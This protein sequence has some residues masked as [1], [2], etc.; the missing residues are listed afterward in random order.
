MSGQPKKILTFGTFDLFHMGHFYYLQA[1]RQF[2]DHITA[3]VARDA[4]VQRH[5]EHL[6]WEKEQIRLAK[7]QRSGLVDE[8]RLGYADW[9]RH[10]E[11]LSDVKPD[12]ICL[13]FDQKAKIP[14][15]PYAV[16]R[17]PSYKPHI[18]KT[19]LIKK[20]VLDVGIE[21]QQSSLLV[22]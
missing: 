2:G 5:K 14:D 1:C 3:I 4:N 19:S 10:L 18:Y 21:P 13:G 20:S 7:L 16:I 8:A 11:V 15:G 22:K 6:P 9:G 12:V 17:I